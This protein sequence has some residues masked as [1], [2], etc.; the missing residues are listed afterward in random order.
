MPRVFNQNTTLKMKNYLFFLSVCLFGFSVNG[1]AQD[2]PSTP[3]S[4]KESEVIFK[5]V[6]KMP[7]FPGCENTSDND[8]DKKKCADE[9]MLQ[10]IYKNLIYPKEARKNNV[11][12]MAVV[13][14]IIDPTGL[15]TDVEL[16]RD[17]GA[18]CGEAAVTV[19]KQMNDL[20]ER[21]TPGLQRGKPVSVQYTL[22]IKFRL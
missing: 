17:P 13:K 16:K 12:G 10:Y 6:E 20:P 4:P 18:G 9:K 8:R 11:E 5:V 14:F 7:R 21:W 2:K 1:Y 22:P 3:L 15:I 19:V